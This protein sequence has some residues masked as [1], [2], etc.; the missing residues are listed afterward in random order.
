MN[1]APGNGGIAVDLSG[2]LFAATQ[3]ISRLKKELAAALTP[4]S[5]P[6]GGSGWPS[7]EEVARVIR[8]AIGKARVSQ[9]QADW[10][11]HRVLALFPPVAGWR[12]IDQDTPRDTLILSVN[13]YGVV[14]TICMGPGGWDDGYGD[15]DDAP[16]FNPRVWQ[17]LPAAPDHIGET[18]EMVRDQTD[19]V[20]E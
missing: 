20:G 14:G 7:K 12:P 13:R 2:E 11:A 8:S 17:P 3:E 10:A 4:S 9:S 6:S 18:N 16:P 1:T 5:P 19:G 15:E